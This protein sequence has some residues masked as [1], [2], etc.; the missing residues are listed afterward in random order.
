MTCQRRLSHRGSVKALL[1]ALY[2]ERI[3]ARGA[4]WT[5]AFWLPT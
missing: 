2:D 3:S 4:I 1:P 5:L